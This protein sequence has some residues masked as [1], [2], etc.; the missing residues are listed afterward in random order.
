MVL[1]PPEGMK[2]TAI[3]LQTRIEATVASVI[4]LLLPDKNTHKDIAITSNPLAIATDLDKQQPFDYTNS[5]KITR[6]QVTII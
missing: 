6:P 3:D 5:R 2:E 1:N 4:T